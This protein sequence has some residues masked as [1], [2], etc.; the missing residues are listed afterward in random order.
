[1]GEGYNKEW[2]TPVKHSLGVGDLVWVSRPPKL[3]MVMGFEQ[4]VFR[5]VQRLVIVWIFDFEGSY[6]FLP[7]DCE[8][9][10]D[11]FCPGQSSKM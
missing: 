5:R 7:E 4:A 6:R 10:T 11:T 2:Y 9:V 8:E 1:M 3:A